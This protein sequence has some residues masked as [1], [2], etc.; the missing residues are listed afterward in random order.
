MPEANFNPYAAPKADLSPPSGP[1]DRRGSPR[2]VP[3]WSGLRWL[4]RACGLVVRRPLSWLGALLLVEALTVAGSLL[5]PRLADAGWLA[6]RSTLTII[7]VNLIE[8]STRSGAPATSYLC[9][10]QIM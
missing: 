7:L 9:T 2:R 1:E 6:S 8:I 5:L 4:A 10:V 3:F